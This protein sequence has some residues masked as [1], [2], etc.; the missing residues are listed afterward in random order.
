MAVWTSLVASVYMR[1]GPTG[2]CCGSGLSGAA[3]AANMPNAVHFPTVGTAPVSFSSL[4][5]LTP[6]PSPVPTR[7]PLHRHAAHST[8]PAGAVL[9]GAIPRR[10]FFLFPQHR[11]RPP[12]AHTADCASSDFLLLV[13]PRQLWCYTSGPAFFEAAPR[14]RYS[15]N[16]CHLH[17]EHRRSGRDVVARSAHTRAVCPRVP[18][19]M[20]CLTLCVR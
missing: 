18:K 19:Y 8:S 12:F 14:D 3:A 17:P 1:I 13:H 7:R 11:R 5:S 16:G 6:S 10:Q 9:S 2:A 15:E 20:P 4:C